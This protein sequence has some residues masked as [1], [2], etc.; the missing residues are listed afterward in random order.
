M[1]TEVTIPDAEGGDVT[2]QDAARPNLPI[3]LKITAGL[4]AMGGVCGAGAGIAL[5]YLGH[6]ISG[7]QVPLTLGVYEWNASIMA[8]IGATLGPPMVWTMLRRVPLWRTLLEPAVAAVAASALSMLF[9]PA[10]FVLAVPA[11]VT[12]AALRLQRAY[13]DRDE[14]ARPSAQLEGDPDRLEDGL[15]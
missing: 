1:T 4:V 8:V 2:A 3:H 15:P 6:V 10:L 11:A 5:T 9:A 7:Y 12:G 13:R 14:D